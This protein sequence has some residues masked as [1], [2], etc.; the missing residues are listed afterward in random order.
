MSKLIRTI[1]C[2]T[3]CMLLV[4]VTALHAAWIVNG[5]P[6]C[7][8]PGLQTVAMVTPDGAG[9][10]IVC[11]YEII[12][13]NN[14][15]DIFA[16]RVD[17]SGTI[18]WTGS[19]V[20]ICTDGQSM[21]DMQIVPDGDGG[22]II[23]WEDYR[24]EDTVWIYAQ[25][26]NASGSVQWAVDGVAVSIGLNPA[27]ITDDAGGAIITF[28]RLVDGGRVVYAQR[29]NASGVLLWA[30]DGVAICTADSSQGGPL[31]TTDGAGGAIIAWRDTRGESDA[32]IYAQRIDASGAVQW[33]VD[34]VA[35]CTASLSQDYHNIISDDAGGAIITWMDTRSAVGSDIYAQRVDAFGSVQWMID[36]VVICT[37]TG[38]EW[39]PKAASDGANGA[40][41]T[42]EDER[43]G[44]G[45][46]YAQHVNSA[47]AVQWTVDGVAVCVAIDD[48]IG[49]CIISDDGGGAII[50]WCDQRNGSDWDI[51]AQRVDAIGTALWADQGVAICAET[52]DQLSSIANQVTSDGYGGAIFAWKDKRSGEYDIYAQVVSAEGNPGEHS[53]ATVLYS[54]SAYVIERAVRVSWLLSEVGENV[55][56]SVLRSRCAS[57]YAPIDPA[58]EEDGLSYSFV[59]DM[60]EPNENYRYRIDISNEEGSHILFETD[61]VAVPAADLILHQNIP[62]PFNPSTT[63]NYY[64]PEYSMVTLGVFDVSGRL[65]VK[66]V[67]E[68]QEC[69]EHSAVWSGTD[70][71]GNPVNSGIYM[72]RLRSGKEALSRK[73]I[74]IQ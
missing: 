58:I 70:T 11:W 4:S 53:V 30:S 22:A 33:A 49:P 10:A 64:V 45:N 50:G 74:L 24:N 72:Y 25:R 66:L 34:G 56:F 2:I 62:N 59:D 65:V 63:I 41:I 57:D 47:G 37:A 1:P 15:W 52:G 6:I 61:R 17:S 21:H 23:V 7:T 46:I 29:V 35:I 12:N 3:L 42:W 54:Y 16:Q 26:V 38:N 44:S 32:D 55:S 5:V 18:Q 39:H 19:G 40:I 8:A 9:G 28:G 60:V 14:D 43:D 51:Y 36:G 48:Q 68:F 69:G 27:V 73:M 67:N 20:L 71:Y 31:I 13:Y